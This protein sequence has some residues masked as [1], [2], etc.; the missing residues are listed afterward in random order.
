MLQVL[1]KNTGNINCYL[2]RRQ[3]SPD[4]ETGLTVPENEILDEKSIKRALRCV[5]C[6]YI[7]SFQE[8]HCERA[9]SH[10]H[11]QVNPHGATFAFGCFAIAPGVT[12]A[13]PPTQE[14][15]WFPGYEW[16]VI[17]CTNCRGHIGWLFSQ[18]QDHFYGLLF[19]KIFSA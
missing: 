14:F 9:G 3:S 8:A 10:E 16:Q 18:P 12:A 4:A 6:D 2:F 17:V 13:S 11:L 7:I 15:S 1:T 19:E 5:T